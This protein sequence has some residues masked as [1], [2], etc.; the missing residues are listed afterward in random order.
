MSPWTMEINTS[1]GC[2]DNALGRYGLLEKAEENSCKRSAYNQECP[3]A[4]GSGEMSC[5]CLCELVP[6]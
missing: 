3:L 1:H 5:I 6:L 4:I 2:I